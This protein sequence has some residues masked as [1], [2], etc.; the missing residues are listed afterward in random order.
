M[1]DV[2]CSFSERK[3][4]T[5]SLDMDTILSIARIIVQTPEAG[6]PWPIIDLDACI[7]ISSFLAP[8]KTAEIAP[9]SMGSP[10][11]VPVPCKCIALT[12]PFFLVDDSAV[13][14]SAPRTTA[15]CD[16]PFGTVSELDLPSWLTHVPTIAVAAIITRSIAVAVIESTKPNA[17][18]PSPLLYPFALTSSVLHRPSGAIIPARI[19]ITV[20]SGTCMRLMPATSAAC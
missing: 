19:N 4:N 9:T 5:E 6:S 12:M 15:C 14:L 18:T 1:I 10:R 16:G 20:V 7:T 13:A 2:I 8:L 11:V 17:P 3:C